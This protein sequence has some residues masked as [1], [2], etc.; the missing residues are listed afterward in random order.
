MRDAL[1]AAKTKAAKAKAHYEFALF[2]DNNSREAEAIPHYR[3]ALR[4]GLPTQIRQAR[5]GRRG[6]SLW[7]KRPPSKRLA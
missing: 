2:H 4:L 1:A 3:A 6:T 5:Y 7:R